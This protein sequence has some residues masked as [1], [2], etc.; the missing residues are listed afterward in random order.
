V[1]SVGGTYHVEP[2]IAIAFSSGG[3]SDTWARPAYQE[4]A[5]SAYLDQLGDRWDGLYNR[6]G[7]GFPDVA[8]QSYRFHV[9]D[10]GNETL[11]SG[12]S[13]FAGIVA[14]LNA[15]RIQAGKPTLGFLNPWIY[16]TAYKGLNDI[17]GG[18]SKGCT[19]T[20]IYSGLPAPFVPY[21]S[22]NATPGW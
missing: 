8:A 10:K 14:L 16:S 19:G 9:I 2:E 3:F 1:T 5:V 15:A 11:L 22:W 4:D 13:A 21:A 17:V 12:T 6:T 20:D 18:G 7:R